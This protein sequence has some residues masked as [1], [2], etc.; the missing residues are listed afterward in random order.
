MPKA[1]V[2]TL[3]EQDFP[4]FQQALKS[5][6]PKTADQIRAL[7]NF[8]GG[9]NGSWTSH[10]G[11]ETDVNDMLKRFSAKALAGPVHEA[12]LGQDRITRRG[13]ARLWQSWRSPLANWSPNDLARMRSICLTV[14]QEARYYPTRQS[15]FVRMERWA[16]DLPPDEVK[17][18]L[19]AGLRDPHLGVRRSAMLAVGRLQQ[20]FA[21]PYL[22]QRLK[23]EK[24]D[25]DPLP[26]V[27]SQEQSHVPS[28]F[29][30][31]AGKRTEAEVAALALGY[32]VHSEAAPLIKQKQPPS[33]MYEVALALLGH[34]ER[35]KPEQF[36]LG[37]QNKELQL[38]AVDAVVR[39][40]SRRGLDFVLKYKQATHWWEEK[41]VV[42]RVT[43]MLLAEKAPGEALLKSC[44]GLKQ[45][46]A[47]YDQ[48]GAEYLQRFSMLP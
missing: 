47:W 36:H 44:S 21:I 43:T 29:D 38:A 3:I 8:E 13:A 7:L 20:K 19:R 25:T 17:R 28:G 23:G 27:S 46:A 1:A 22:L 32:L 37:E 2:E 14:M 31:V 5:G 24:A 4:K 40:K 48:H 12:L 30:H 45:L 41:R 33:P 11:V 18:R 9:P 42:E 26:H 35:L 10:S 16:A 6:L 39:A 15:A 34:V